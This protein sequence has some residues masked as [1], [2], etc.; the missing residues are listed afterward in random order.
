MTDKLSP[1][2][3]AV[4]WQAVNDAHKAIEALIHSEQNPGSFKLERVAGDAV[5]TARKSKSALAKYK[6][7]QEPKS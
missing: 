3:L 1:E 5:L 4:W 7:R 2:D 6:A